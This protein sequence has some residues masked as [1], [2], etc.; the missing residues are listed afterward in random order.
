MRLPVIFAVSGVGARP[1]QRQPAAQRL[2]PLGLQRRV[3]HP[4]SHPS[5]ADK[6]LLRWPL[7]NDRRPDLVHA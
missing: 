2:C 5:G 3:R 1:L 6:R 7:T 4:G